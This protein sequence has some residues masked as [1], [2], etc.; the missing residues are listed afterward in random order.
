VDAAVVL[1]NDTDADGEGVWSDAPML[2]SGT[3]IAG[4]TTT[5][6]W[7]GAA[8]MGCRFAEVI[9]AAQPTPKRG[10]ERWSFRF[11]RRPQTGRFVRPMAQVRRKGL[12]E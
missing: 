9:S 4:I 7:F 10:R 1:T 6:V 3:E 5:G 8:C 11:R 2:A 12:S